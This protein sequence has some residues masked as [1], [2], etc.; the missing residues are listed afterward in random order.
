MKYSSLLSTIVVIA[1]FLILGFIGCD[2]GEWHELAKFEGSSNKRTEDFII[3][4]SARQSRIKSIVEPF[5]EDYHFCYSLFKKDN[6]EP[7]ISFTQSPDENTGLSTQKGSWIIEE[8]GTLYFEVEANNCDWQI[9]IES[10][11]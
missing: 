3:P 8:T 11:Y 5:S 10:H 7:Y 2:S 4:N 6:V 9:S 1:M